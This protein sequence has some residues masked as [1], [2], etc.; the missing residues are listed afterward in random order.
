MKPKRIEPRP[1]GSDSWICDR[2]A[3]LRI[4]SEK[5]LI[6]AQSFLSHFLARTSYKAVIK[7]FQSLLF[8]GFARYLP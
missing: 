5:I 7:L 3:S 6:R 2:Y 1:S 4:A 8:I